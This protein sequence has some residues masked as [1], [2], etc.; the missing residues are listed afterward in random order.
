LQTSFAIA[1]HLLTPAR[2]V[3]SPNQSSRPTDSEISLLVIHNISLP[4]GQFGG[5]YVDQLFCNCL[6]CRVHPFFTE[7]AEL[8]VSA[9]LL[10]D[11]EGEVSQY[12]PF[13]R[14]AWHCGV[15]CYGSRDNCNEFSIGIE[16]EGTDDT[17]FTTAQYQVLA[18]VTRVIMAAYPAISP[19]RIVGHSDIAPGR[20]TDPGPCFNWDRYRSAIRQPRRRQVAE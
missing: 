18:V 4:P 1:D 10:I 3:N 9:H 12:V 17:P 8:R 11:R 15:S 6:D 5:G 16:L 14:K 13:H 7:I 2:Q 19:E 20:K